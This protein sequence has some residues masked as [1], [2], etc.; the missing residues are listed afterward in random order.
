MCISQTLADTY[1]FHIVQGADGL[2]G[3]GYADGRGGSGERTFEV[4]VKA[5]RGVWYKNSTKFR[6]ENCRKTTNHETVARPTFEL[7][8]GF[9]ARA[10]I[11]ET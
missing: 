5:L 2:R 3:N 11:V 9:T 1:K 10:V 6:P 8:I 7:L 4:G